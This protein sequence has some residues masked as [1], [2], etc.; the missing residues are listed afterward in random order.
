[1]EL[2]NRDRELPL[3]DERKV[4]AGDWGE[5][6]NLIVRCLLHTVGK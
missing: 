4:M 6:R 1:M 2:D 5:W 3:F